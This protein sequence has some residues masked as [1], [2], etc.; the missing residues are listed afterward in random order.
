[1]SE[2]STAGAR[3]P[4]TEAEPYKVDG[5]RAAVSELSTDGPR[6]PE[7]MR[8]W[9]KVDDDCPAE[10]ELRNVMPEPLACALE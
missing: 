5:A 7:T 10:P 8:E 1:M 2:L 6:W 4:K 3:W 9:C